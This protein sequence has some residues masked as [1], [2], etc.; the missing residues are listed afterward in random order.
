[1]WKGATVVLAASGPSQNK[2]DLDYCC[3]KARLIAI[4]TTYRLV[5]CADILYACDRQWWDHYKPTFAGWCVTRDEKAARRHNLVHMP[6]ARRDGLSLTWPTI[7]EGE[8]SGYQALNLAVLLGA[9]R[10]VLTG[11]DMGGVGH[12]HGQH[13][14]GLRNPDERNFARWRDRFATTL[15]DLER[16]G[17]QVINCTRDTAL[18]CFP[19]AKLEET[20]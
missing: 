19:R 9:R 13:R 4:N 18:T 8:N 12:W 5:P 1:M 14:G 3:G 2:S 16:A 6:S 17:A 20:L 11:Y 7:H 15:A 10:I